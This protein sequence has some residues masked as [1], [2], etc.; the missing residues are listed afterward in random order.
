MKYLIF[1][2]TILSFALQAQDSKGFN[3]QSVIRDSDGRIIPNRDATLIFEIE[4]ISSGDIVYEESH[5][6]ISSDLGMIN[7]VIGK[8]QPSIGNFDLI[9]WEL[10]SYAAHITIDLNDGNGPSDLGAYILKSVPYA[11]HAQTVENN[12]DADADPSN[13]LQNLSLSGNTLSLSNGGSVDLSSINN[14]EPLWEVLADSSLRYLKGN[15]HTKNIFLDKGSSVYTNLGD[16]ISDHEDYRGQYGWGSATLYYEPSSS[17]PEDWRAGSVWPERIEITDGNNKVL[18]KLSEDK[19]ELKADD[20]NVELSKKNLLFSSV[21][22]P[23]GISSMNRDSLNFQQILSS[24]TL[25]AYALELDY[26]FDGLTTTLEADR[27]EFEKRISPQDRF[28]TTLL[29]NDSLMMYN[30][31]K[32]AHTF[33]GQNTYTNAGQLTFFEGVDNFTTMNLGSLEDFNGAG[34]WIFGRDGTG[35]TLDNY[36]GY[37]QMC[38]FD[39]TAR[40]L[41]QT[42]ASGF[43]GGGQL[44]ILDTNNTEKIRA[45]IE[46]VDGL[47]G[48]EL[49]GVIEIDGYADANRFQASYEDSLYT[50]ISLEGIA[51]SGVFSLTNKTLNSPDLIKPSILGFQ[52]LEGSGFWGLYGPNS[53]NIQLTHVND[54]ETGG[55]LPDLGGVYVLDENSNR[56]AG[57]DIDPIT[58][59]GVV[60]GDVKNFRMDH[61]EDDAKEIVYA[62]L[63]GPEAAAY[64][65]GTAQL[66]NGRTFVEFPD[67]FALVANPETM[68]VILTPQYSQTFGVAVVEKTDRGFYVEE[69]MNGKQGFEFDW[70]VKCVR[71]G[72]EDFKVV[73]TK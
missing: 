62:S 48:Q 44:T 46:P 26:T 20:I 69:L 31:Q 54:P 21:N 68:T 27:L 43:F 7:L 67:H 45:F 29:T 34:L 1:L 60:W 4:E 61:P 23:S 10:Y 53:T 25:D 12:D 16:F 17:A 63:E 36:N 42:E 64:A 14:S 6:V 35:I 55:A 56:K 73:R 13:E 49:I 41:V 30:D 59:Q 58:G 24:S 32:W 11:M 5:E 33:L 22:S 37:G 52:N 8:G 71:K 28:R 38:L 40:C 50:E 65:R 19:L 9:K 72:Y 15:L 2:F 66:T 57:V 47:N 51:T 39:Q 3:Y 70:E 18:S